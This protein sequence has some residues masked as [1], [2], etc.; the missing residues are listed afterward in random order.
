MN[1]NQRPAQRA[2][3]IDLAKYL[4][5]NQEAAAEYAGGLKAAKERVEQ[6][7]YLVI[8]VAFGLAVV[9]EWRDMA[10][11]QPPRQ[12]LLLE[13][14]MLQTVTDPL[15][16]ALFGLHAHAVQVLETLERGA[17]A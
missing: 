10:A 17:L 8:G 4:A 14:K 2:E 12:E 13:P 9:G 3:I 11:A 1:E 15:V 5:E 6:V 7:A 16:A